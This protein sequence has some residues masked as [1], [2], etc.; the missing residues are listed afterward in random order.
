MKDLLINSLMRSISKYCNYDKEKLAIIK[1]GLASL[2]LHFTKMIVIFLISY[3]MGNF[4][5]LLILMGFY[6]ILRLTGYGVHAKKSIHCWIASLITFLI[7]P[8]LCEKTIITYEI[9]ILL[10]IISIILLSMYAPADTEKR[11]LIN[12]KRRTVFKIITI[13]IGI[14]YTV[15]L[16]TLNNNVISNCLLY[17]LILETIVVLPITYKIFG[18]KYKNYKNYKRKEK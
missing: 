10:S 18:V 9:K 15:T 14:I 8:M 16:L 6:S 17:A 12:K 1:Y 2:Y 3:L 7:I 13:I 11:P 5:T 4:R